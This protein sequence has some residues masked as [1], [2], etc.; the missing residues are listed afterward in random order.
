MR[1]VLVAIALLPMAVAWCS[2]DSVT[3]P[4]PSS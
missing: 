2:K 1:L 3:R 4:D